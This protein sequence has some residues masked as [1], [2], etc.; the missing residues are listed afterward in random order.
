MKAPRRKVI[1]ALLW[2][3]TEVS[4]PSVWRCVDTVSYLLVHVPSG[5]MSTCC[6]P[7]P[8][9]LLSFIVSKVFFRESGSVRCTNRGCVYLAKHAYFAG[10]WEARLHLMR[11]PKKG[12]FFVSALATTLGAPM[13]ATARASK[14][15]ECGATQSIG[16]ASEGAWSGEGEIM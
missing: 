15:V 5:K 8:S 11:L 3:R 4:A 16:A 14:N 7:F 1:R 13:T 2:D 10:S 9:T 6:Q 12:T